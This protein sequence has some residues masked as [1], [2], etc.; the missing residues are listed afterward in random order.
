MRYWKRLN[1]DNSINTV[2]GYSHDL[3]IPGA[4]E[5]SQADFDTFIRNLPPVV[6][7]SMRDALAEVDS[8]RAQLKA[9]GVLV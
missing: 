6:T 5:I 1:P 2:E 9:N 8:L 4:K 3:D 7:P